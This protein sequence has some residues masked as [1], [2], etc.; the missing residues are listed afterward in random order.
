MASEQ[1]VSTAKA[2]THQPTSRLPSD[3]ARDATYLQQRSS[4][5]VPPGGNPNLDY[6]CLTRGG[7]K[8]RGWAMHEIMCP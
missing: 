7:E 6:S 5:K 3:T 4:P 8:S 1:A 2:V